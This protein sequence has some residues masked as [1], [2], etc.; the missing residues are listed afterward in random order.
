MPKS[1]IDYGFY[2]VQRGEVGHIA[3]AKHP[4]GFYGKA[5]NDGSGNPTIG[6]GT[7]MSSKKSSIG[8]YKKNTISREESVDLTQREMVV[9]INE[10]CKNIVPNFD[11]LLP[12]YQAVLIDSAFQGKQRKLTGLGKGNVSGARDSIMNKEGNKERKA[13]RG[14]A[15][16]MGMMIEK[17]HR[18]NPNANPKDA[19]KSVCDALI[20]KYGHL[21]GDTELTKDELA[22]AYHSCNFAYGVPS[23]DVEVEA[24]ALSHLQV[25]SGLMGIGSS[26]RPP[27]CSYYQNAG[28]SKESQMAQNESSQNKQPTWWQRRMPVFLGGWSSERLAAA[29]IGN[30]SQTT[31]VSVEPKP[32]NLSTSQTGFRLGGLT[33]EQQ[34]SMFSAE[35]IK[36]IENIF[37]Q[38]RSLISTLDNA[39]ENVAVPPITSR[40]IAS[41]IGQ[42]RANLVIES[43]MKAQQNS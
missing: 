1:I 5:Y 2:L 15:L 17:Y 36:Q 13:V 19:A 28:E 42:K 25:S 32:D 22:M 31:P 37:N 10:K 11:N 34:N 35:E 33:M 16:E 23:D 21:K 4:F 7:V 8:G 9:K 38:K 30:Y 27:L 20:A 39:A 43:A 14:R 41:V 12:C 26:W 29:G 3:S 24:F 18:E 6:I 40:E